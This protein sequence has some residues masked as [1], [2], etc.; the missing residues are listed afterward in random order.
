MCTFKLQFKG[1][2]T[3]FTCSKLFFHI[4]VHL[5]TMPRYSAIAK[6]LMNFLL[7]ADSPDISNHHAQYCFSQMSGQ[8]YIYVYMLICWSEKIKVLL[9]KNKALQNSNVYM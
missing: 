7:R 9:Y 2:F 5:L 6:Y 1:H 3:G 4:F 8:R